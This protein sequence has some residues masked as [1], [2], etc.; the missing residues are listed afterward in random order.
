MNAIIVGHVEIDDLWIEIPT[1]ESMT[2]DE[3]ISRSGMS[4]RDG[5]AARCF[6]VN[7]DPVSDGVVMPGD[8]VVVGSRPPVVAQIDASLHDDVMIRWTRNIDNRGNLFNGSGLLE[9]PCTLWVPGVT[10]GSR[11]RAVEITRHTNRNGKIHAQGYQVRSEEDPYHRG[12]LVLVGRNGEDRMKL[13]D[14]VSGRLSIDVTI[15][16]NSLE[17]A[18]REE[19]ESGRR[20]IWTLK[21]TNFDSDRRTALASVERG[22][23]WW[24]K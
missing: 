6:L 9:G 17:A 8:T 18:K 12:D 22:Y 20:A 10:I 3:V 4:P 11:I 14:P 19:L 24:R 5:T 23:T 13:F 16:Q 21:I 7:G 2:A 15:Q 1:E